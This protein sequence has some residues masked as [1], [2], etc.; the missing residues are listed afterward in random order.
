MKEDQTI[1]LREIIKQRDLLA[2]H[3]P[4]VIYQY[5][6]RPDGTSHFP[7]VSGGMLDVLG[8]APEKIIDDGSIV[9]YGYLHDKTELKKVQ[10]KHQLNEEKNRNLIAKMTN[11]FALHEMI[12]KAISSARSIMNGLRPAKLEM[13]GFAGATYEYINDF[14]SLFNLRVESEIDFDIA[15][16]DEERSLALYRILQESLNNIVKHAKATKV[17]V[18]YKQEGNN[19]LFEV[20]DNGVGFNIEKSGREDSYGLLGIK[21]RVILLDGTISIDSAPGKGT[22]ISVRFPI[23][24]QDADLSGI[25]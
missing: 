3:I 17:K 19:I 23:S 25:E 8:I 24:Q 14:A 12:V 7:Y 11:A 22:R 1:K 13:L 6:I 16:P 2:N 10:E 9:W 4:G 18:V 21:E 15:K 5:R 20:S